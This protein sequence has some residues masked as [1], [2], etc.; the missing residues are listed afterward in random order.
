MSLRSQKRMAASLLKVGLSRLR[1]DPDELEKVESAITKDEVRRLIHEGVISARVKK[2]V[3]RGRFRVKAAKRLRRG[4][5][6]RKGSSSIRKRDWA[7]KI[8]SLRARLRELKMKRMI[9]GETYRRLMPMA[10]GGAFR[11]IPHLNEY[12]EAHNLVRRR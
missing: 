6:S 4:L 3:S 1:I 5:G 10:K 8:R 7:A 11:N 9:T 12:L 2:G